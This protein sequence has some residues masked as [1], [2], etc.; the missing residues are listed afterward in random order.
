MN[1][2]PPVSENE[3]RIVTSGPHTF[4]IVNGVRLWLSPVP[5]DVQSDLVPNPYSAAS[6]S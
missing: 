1:Q 4:R 6:S 2:L 5:G 3:G